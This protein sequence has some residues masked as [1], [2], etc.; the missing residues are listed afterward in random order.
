M[1]LALVF[2]DPLHLAIA[3]GPLAVYLL[4]LGAI[5]LSRRPFLTTGARDAAALGVGILGLIFAGPMELFLPEQAVSRFGPYVWLLLLVLYGLCLT[6]LVLVLRPRLVVYNLSLEQLWPVLGETAAALDEEAR[7]AG[8][9]LVLPRLGVSLYVEPFAALRN[10]QLVSA[11]PRQNYAGWRRL[12]TA[13]RTA[14]R[15]TT[16]APNPYGGSLILLGAAMVCLVLYSVL[17]QPDAVAAAF[18]EMLRR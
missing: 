18:N 10:V 9:N 15:E 11:G 6:L 7:W 12:E 5:N 4:M 2:M 13:L 8:M 14:L 16:T 1:A 17:S 3:L